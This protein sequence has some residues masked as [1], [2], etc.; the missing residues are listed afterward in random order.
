MSDFEL[1]W[2]FEVSVVVSHLHCR[3]MLHSIRH[4]R[5]Y[6]QSFCGTDFQ[7]VLVHVIVILLSMITKIAKKIAVLCKFYQDHQW[8]CRVKQFA[9]NK[10]NKV[11]A[12]V[13][14]DN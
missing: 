11:W 3:K 6:P 5:S 4:V 1:E 13:T 10:G 14:L 2:R 7:R 12:E 9:G 8:S